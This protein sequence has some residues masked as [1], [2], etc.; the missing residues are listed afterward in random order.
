VRIL[1]TTKSW[2]LRALR[3]VG[4]ALSLAALLSV[5]CGDDGEPSLVCVEDLPSACSPTFPADYDTIYTML[6]QQRCG[7]AG[8]NGGC[9]SS[10]DKA[11]GLDL[12]DPGR[13]YQE[14]LGSNGPAR[15]KPGDPSC[16]V[17]MARLESDDP[18]VRMPLGE[19]RLSA[20]VRCAVQRW[21]ADGAKQP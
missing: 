13:A 12:S 19:A 1:T 10:I 9:H 5:G 20:G 7:T 16:S 18:E 17:L 4:R 21:I 6:F 15:V 14:L 3:L 2:A 11:G 8:S